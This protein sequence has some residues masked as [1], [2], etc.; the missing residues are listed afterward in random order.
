MGYEASFINRVGPALLR[1]VKDE[2]PSAVLIDLSRLPSQGRDVA[3][4]LR[5]TGATRQLPIVFVDGLP[6]KVMLVRQTLPDATYSTWTHLADDLDRAIRRPARDPLVP[7]AGKSGTGNLS[8]TAKLGI[9]EDSKI[10][11]LGAP[12]DFLDTL[13]Q[14][15]KGASVR[16]QLG[17]GSDLVV[18][19]VRSRRELNESLRL[20]LARLGSSDLW[21]FWLK[22]TSGQTG[23]LLQA[24]VRQLAL[25]HGLVE[26]KSTS[27]DA[28]WSGMLFKKK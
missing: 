13:G 15:P 20:R 26:H 2:Q 11:I 24:D 14:L 27:L 19:F 12:H 23:D 7:D 17:E 10:V 3:V 18:W 4:S 25:E 16:S 22:K 21:I 8:L 1:K 6:E 9:K 5:L 28:T